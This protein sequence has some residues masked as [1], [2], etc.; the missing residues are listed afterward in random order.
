MPGEDPINKDRIV[1]SL[2]LLRIVVQEKVPLDDADFGLCP[3]H[4]EKTPSFHIFKASSGRARFHCFGCGVGGDIFNYLRAADNI[5]F[6]SAV[7]KLSTVLNREIDTTKIQPVT[8]SSRAPEWTARV[9]PDQITPFCER[10]CGKYKALREDYNILLEENDIL[11]ERLGL[12]E[13]RP[14]NESS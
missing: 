1:R 3:F 7:F 5:G 2:D 10:D 11:R 13:F 4:E 9:A 12:G 14:S 6:S 8:S